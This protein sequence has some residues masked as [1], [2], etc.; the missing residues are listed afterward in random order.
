AGVNVVGNIITGDYFSEYGPLGPGEAVRL[1]FRAMIDPNLADGTTVTNL[2]RVAWNDPAQYATAEVSN[3]VGGVPNAGMISGNV[4]H[5]AD[6]DNTPDAVER[7]L[8]GWT[9]ELMRDDQTFRTALTDVD[10]N[11]LFSGLP[12]NYLTGETYS[13]RFSAPGA[14]SRTAMMGVADSDFTDGMQRI[15]EINVQGGSN[16]LALNMPVDPHGV[17]YDSVARTPIAGA[18]VTM[19]DVRNDLA[20]PSACFDDPNQQDQVTVSNGY[21]KFDMNFSDPACPPGI[22]YT[23]QVTPP[24]STYVPGV[25]ELIPPASDPSTLPFDVPACPGSTTDAVLATSQYCE[26]QPSEFQPPASVPARSSATDY[27]SYLRLDD[28]G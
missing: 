14:G 18:T 19:I 15:D 5:D 27:H 1:R 2:G 9:V 10:G 25:S 17:I 26:A 11:Y 23:I 4:F 21:Y 7:P 13:L 16:L 12:P 8:E 3:D 6:H 20:I 24:N 28:S 22:N